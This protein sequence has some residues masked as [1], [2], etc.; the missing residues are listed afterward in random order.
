MSPSFPVTTKEI[1]LNV[2]FALTGLVNFNQFVLEKVIVQLIHFVVEED[3]GEHVQKLG[4]ILV[5]LAFVLM[6]HH[7]YVLNILIVKA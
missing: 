7:Q 3:V 5:I 1:A 4:V 6:S 2:T